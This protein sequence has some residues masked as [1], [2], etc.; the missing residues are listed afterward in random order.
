MSGTAWTELQTVL[1]TLT[2]RQRDTYHERVDSWKRLLQLA[3]LPDEALLHIAQAV[4]N[5]T[6]PNGPTLRRIV[7]QFGT[8]EPPAAA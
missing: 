2:T 6:H 4:A 8:R 5:R 7:E 3:A 1:A